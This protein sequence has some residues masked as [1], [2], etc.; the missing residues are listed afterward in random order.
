MSELET[1]LPWSSTLTALADGVG[2]SLRER[3]TLVPVAQRRAGSVTAEACSWDGS[4]RVVVAADGAVTSIALS[5]SAFDRNT[6]EALATI[7]MAT[8][9]TA[10]AEARAQAGEAWQSFRA[11]D[12][13]VLAA[14]A[15]AAGGFDV[16]TD[17]W[18]R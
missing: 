18:S 14:T 11:D 9:Q 13:T 1:P 4:V 16:L 15:R 2:A 8:V 6:P 17:H 7:V 5:L 12:A 10:A 3:A